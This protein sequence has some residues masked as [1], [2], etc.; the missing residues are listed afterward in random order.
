MLGQQIADGCDRARLAHAP[1]LDDEDADAV[2]LLDDRP[3]RGG[4]ADHHS[5]ERQPRGIG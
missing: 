3:G 2:E 5:L 4:A 1:G